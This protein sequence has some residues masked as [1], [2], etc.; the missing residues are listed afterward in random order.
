MT[1]YDDDKVFDADGISVIPNMDIF[2]E[3][4]S[5]MI[6]SL[7]KVICST[8]CISFYITSSAVMLLISEALHF[9]NVSDYVHIPSSRSAAVCC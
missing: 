6:L 5:G 8:V 3:I 2:L 4:L 9:M 7:C 1:V